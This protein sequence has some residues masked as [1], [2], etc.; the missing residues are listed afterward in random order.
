MRSSFCQWTA[1]RK[2]IAVQHELEDRQGEVLGA[3]ALRAAALTPVH[4]GIVNRCQQVPA[5]KR[6]PR[7][8]HW[9]QTGIEQHRK[10]LAFP[11]SA[12]LSGTS[13]MHV[14]SNQELLLSFIVMH[15][16]CHDLCQA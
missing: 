6:R 2:K 7:L 12:L 1:T 11:I 15:G 14:W 16:C 13:C 9:Y 10:Q 4:T 3:P 8:P 5:R